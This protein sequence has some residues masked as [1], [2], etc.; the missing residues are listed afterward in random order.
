MDVGNGDGPGVGAD[1]Y[2]GEK[3]E[4]HQASGIYAKGAKQAT[5]KG[6]RR[7]LLVFSELPRLPSAGG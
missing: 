2:T 3:T 5:K 6:Q 4:F 1:V 7:D